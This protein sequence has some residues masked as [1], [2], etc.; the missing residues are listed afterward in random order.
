[1][2]PS[3]AP[4]ATPAG[5]RTV[6]KA[7]YGLAAALAVVGAVTV[8]D[9]S[10]LN[11]GFGDPVGPR[12]FPYVIG[13]GM[14]VLAVLLA[15]ATARGDVPEAEEG[16]DIDLTTPADWTTVLKLVGIMVLNLVLVNV[17]GWA[18]TGAMLFAGAA[19]ALGSRTLLRD[20][21][22]GAVLSV[23]SWYFFYSGLGVQ[24]T[25]GILD[26]IL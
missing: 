24:L 25:P 9:A 7:Q 15:I 5:A 20:V 16:E 18:I 1:V 2:D 12:V 6:D 14:L 13:T 26:G 11:V 3:G 10:Q 8:V 17:L 19:W 23:G 21:L 22:V 4:P